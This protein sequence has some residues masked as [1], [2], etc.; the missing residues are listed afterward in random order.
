MREDQFCPLLTWGQH[1]VDPTVQTTWTEEANSLSDHVMNDFSLAVSRIEMMLQNSEQC[2]HGAIGTGFFFKKGTLVY[3]ITNWHNLTGVN[4][5]TG[6]ALHSQ[7]LLPNTV[8]IHF[9]R[10]ADSSHDAVKSDC[11]DLPLYSENKPLWFEHS[12]RSTV[13][14]A[15][16]PIHKIPPDW[17]NTY[18]NQVDQEPRLNV[19]AGMDCYILGFPKDLFGAAFTP[20]WKRGSIAAEPYSTHPYFIDSATRKGMSGSPVIARHN[21]ILKFSDGP[22]RGDEII[23]TSERFVAI[24]SSRIGDDELGA[25]LGRAWP[26]EV[27]DDILTLSTPGFHPIA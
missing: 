14:V 7:G 9:K 13:D 19:Y 4:P 15:A 27:L 26:A 3:L 11:F 16:L 25:Q 8:R 18:I 6:K 24:Y 21:G 22:M 1:D 5:E 20:I 23:G 17:A 2:V 10:W 12:G